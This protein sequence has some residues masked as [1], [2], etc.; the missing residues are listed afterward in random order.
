MAEP[1][2]RICL[3]SDRVTAAQEVDHIVPLHLGGHAT[4]RGN[5][6]PLCVNCHLAKS[7][8]ETTGRAFN[9]TPEW[10]WPKGTLTVVCGPPGA[11]KNTYVAQHA[12]PGDAVID[13][14]ELI[15]ELFGVHGHDNTD[16]DKIGTAIGERN[17]RL[18][19]LPDNGTAWLIASAPSMTERAYWK[20]RGATVVLLNPGHIEC[21]RRSSGRSRNYQQAVLRWFANY[22]TVKK[23]SATKQTIGADGWPV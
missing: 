4:E 14:D 8:A 18:S 17:A 22:G 7:N 21:I 23:L 13:L 9:M 6:Q 2:C 5:L 20:E 15:A 10:L 3:A 16:M 11:G 1:L 19:R 12:K